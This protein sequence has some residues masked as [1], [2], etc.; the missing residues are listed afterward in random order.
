[1]TTGPVFPQKAPQR[2]MGQGLSDAFKDTLEGDKKSASLGKTL[3]SLML[4]AAGTAMQGFML[5]IGANPHVDIG[6]AKLPKIANN[7]KAE[8][9]KVV[10]L[11]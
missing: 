9:R 3:S 1:M 11:V 6:E 5:D 7:Y 4:T 10:P 2:T 8:L